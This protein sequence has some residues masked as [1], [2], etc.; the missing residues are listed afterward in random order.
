VA[1]LTLIKTTYRLGETVLGVVTFNGPDS[2]RR[3]LKL[4]AFLETHEVIPEPLLPPSASSSGRVR[5][6]ELRKVH[7]EHR[8]AYALHTARVPF[9]LDIPSDATPAFALAA[10][11][12]PGEHG[13]LEWRVRLAFLVALPPKRGH[14]HAH[15]QSHGH[16]HKHSPSTVPAP[17]PVATVPVT[18]GTAGG[19]VHL[20][21]SERSDADNVS[22]SAAPGLVPFMHDGADFVE[23]RAETVECEV[24]VSVL[25]GNT[26]FV[27]RPSNFVV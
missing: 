23:A 22:F 15:P 17:A 1:V 6:P 14:A 25:A 12:G 5:Q 3:V 19:V 26:A 24:P 18:P 16:G 27:V 11:K 20:L 10:G 2:S 21:P 8:S 7:A 13:G 4:S 9:A